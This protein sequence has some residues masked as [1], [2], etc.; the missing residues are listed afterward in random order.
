MSLQSS[1]RDE[2]RGLDAVNSL[3]K[4]GCTAKFHQ[5]DILSQESIQKLK[6]FLEEQ[7]GGLDILVNNAGIAYKVGNESFS[8]FNFVEGI[9]R[10]DPQKTID[11][12][13]NFRQTTWSAF[14][15]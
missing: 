1:A 12:H 14:L 15:Y 5:L 2:Q 7:Y 13:T 4:E 6:K 11:W 8:G 9:K 3:S 10:K